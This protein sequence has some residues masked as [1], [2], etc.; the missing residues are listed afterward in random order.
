MSGP[1]AGGDRV[2]LSQCA[3]QCAETTCASR[4]SGEWRWRG[5]GT[6]KGV[7]LTWL[8]LTWVRLTWLTWLR[9]SDV[10]EADV[11]ETK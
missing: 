4:L 9:P 2:T 6:E 7:R 1:Q 11:A 8:W 3:I 10:A 5:C